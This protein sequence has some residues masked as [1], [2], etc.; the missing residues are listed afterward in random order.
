MTVLCHGVRGGRSSPQVKAGSMHRRQRRVGGVVAI[1]ERQV[2]VRIA[3]LVAEHRVGPANR[4]ADRLRVRIEDDLVRVESVAVL[5]LV[6]TVD[7]VTV[8]LVRPDVRQV[9]VPDLSG[10]LGQRNADA[11]PSSASGE[12][13]RHSST[14]VA[15]AENS[16]KLTPDAGP[17][18]PEGIRIARPDA[19]ATSL[20]G[21]CQI[22]L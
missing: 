1:V 6:R 20:Q 5:R 9:A 22:K 15:C 18:R 8:E 21:I 13:N 3:D 19:H 11:F 16:A 14:A 10:L 12:S 2:V 7:A 4:R 17:G